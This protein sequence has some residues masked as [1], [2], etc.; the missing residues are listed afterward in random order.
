[1][2]PLPG[3]DLGR[4]PP[5]GHVG[6]SL[7]K[8][9]RFGEVTEPGENHPAGPVGQRTRRDQLSGIVE[10]RETIDV[11]CD[12]ILGKR[13]GPHP[14]QADLVLHGL[15][16]RSAQPGLVQLPVSG[17]MPSASALTERIPNQT[18]AWF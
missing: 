3:P 4:F 15:T 1:M 17:L 7:R 8:S 18:R 12:G 14:A 5:A 16:L 10:M 2:C 6:I 9:L 11:L 13:L